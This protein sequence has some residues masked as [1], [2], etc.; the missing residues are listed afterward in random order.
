MIP[1]LLQEYPEAS[2]GFIGSRTI[3]KSDMVEDYSNTQRFQTYRYFI[4][5]KIGN[6]TFEHF[7]YPGISGYLLINRKNKNIPQKEM[8][9]SKM[10]TETYIT[11]P[12]VAT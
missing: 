1:I 6:K 2:F 11:L 7:E 9:I 3:D 4:S 8:A 5:K 12:D 10:F